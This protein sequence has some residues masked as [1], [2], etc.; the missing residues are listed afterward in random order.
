M[1]A[2]AA[3]SP[4]MGHFWDAL[5]P[6]AV[7]RPMESFRFQPGQTFLCRFQDAAGMCIF[8]FLL[9]QVL[10][11]VMKNR[12]AMDLRL[13]VAA[14]SGILTVSS[15]LLFGAFIFILGEKFM[16]FSPF[17]MVCS[18][19]V[20][21]DGRLQMLYYMNYLLKWYELLDTVF[22]V[23]RKREVIFLHQYH[24]AATL[25]L[26]WIQ[27]DQHSTVQ[28]V[29]ISINLLVHMFMYYYYMLAALRIKVWWKK[30][31]TQLQILQFVIDIAACVYA[32]WHEPVLSGVGLSKYFPNAAECNGT[33]LGATTGVGIIFSYL[34]LF[35]VFYANTYFSKKQAAM[36]GTPH[37]KSE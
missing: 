32:S 23:L 2:K 34:V 10:Q 28:W 3:P 24:H 29:P 35:L 36:C 25:A 33:L 22:L 30:Y 16:R 17:E 9:I 11:A 7:A 31:L 26:C 12:K 1:V 8:Y 19:T 20:H 18:H 27:M 37:S 6:A 5:V 13:P 14:H 21:D 15:T 4:A